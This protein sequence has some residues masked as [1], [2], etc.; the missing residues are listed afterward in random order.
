[1]DSS[2]IQELRVSPA[3]SL[4]ELNDRFWVWLEEFCH[5]RP[6][7]SLDGKSPLQAWQAG[8]GEVRIETPEAI[9]EAFLHS[10]ERKV[11]HT[12]C[13]SFKGGLYSVGVDYAGK[14]VLLRY[15]PADLS[16]ADAFYGGERVAEAKPMK[17]SVQNRGPEPAL[18]AE[19]EKVSF[20]ELIAR[21][22]QRRLKR[23]LG[24]IS[25]CDLEGER[26]V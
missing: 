23:R 13:V 3:L 8:I 7:S 14:R 19:A 2:F 6:H 1:M 15:D 18:A 9:T 17:V 4:Q 20:D 24:A 16:R 12:G 5:R 10:A 11:D 25:F 22:Q 26:D 21:E